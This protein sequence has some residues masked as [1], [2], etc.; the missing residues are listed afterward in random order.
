MYEYIEVFGTD[1]LFNNTSNPTTQLQDIKDYLENTVEPDVKNNTDS[2]DWI[3]NV[4]DSSNKIV[5]VDDCESC[6][7]CQGDDLDS[8]R[9]TAETWLSNN[10]IAYDSSSVCVVADYHTD[11][12][13]GLAGVS[14]G[15]GW[16]TN[17]QKTVVVNTALSLS[18]DPAS[19]WGQIAAHEIGHTLNAEHQDT[20]VYYN[21]G[22]GYY[23]ATHMW[24][25]PIDGTS[26]QCDSG[27][28]ADDLDDSFSSCSFN[29]IDQFL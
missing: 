13:D 14:I 8:R 11:C 10:F 27:N 7:T 28:N 4:W 21:S 5:Q 3:L 17:G 19:N 29:E 6:N 25:P 23:S 22:I 20:A 1:N 26:T 12:P 18:N 9:D 16:N 24:T 15:G 2:D